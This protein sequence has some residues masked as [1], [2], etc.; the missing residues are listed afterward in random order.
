MTPQALTP[1]ALTAAIECL[2]GSVD[3]Q[4]LTDVGIRLNEAL[5]ALGHA[6]VAPER[7]R[8]STDATA[9]AG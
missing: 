3:Q 9:A 2:L 1:Q 4:G 8:R 6:G 7:R 5:V